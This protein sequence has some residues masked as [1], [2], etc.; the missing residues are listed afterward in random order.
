M[1]DRWHRV[2]TLARAAFVTILLFFNVLP[3]FSLVLVM[4]E[5]DDQKQASQAKN[6]Q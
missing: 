2:D 4:T 1:A 6:E 5:P 3:G